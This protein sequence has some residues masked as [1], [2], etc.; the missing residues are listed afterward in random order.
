MGH[1][2]LE[3]I[4][5]VL[6]SRKLF[7]YMPEQAGECDAFE[8]SFAKRVGVRHAL[9]LTSGTNALVAALAAYGIGEGD[10]VIIPAYTFVA[11]AG[12]VRMVGAKPVVVNIDSEFGLSVED[13]R[14]KVTARTKAIL[15]VHMDGLSADMHGILELAREKGLIVIEDCAQA[16]GGS[17]HGRRLGSIGDAG[18]F[19]LNENKII[20]CGEGGIVTTSCSDAFERMMCLQDLSAR[21][22]PSKK[23][24]FSSR[25]QSYVGMSMRVSEIQGAMIRVQLERL[26]PILEK[27]RARKNALI[28]CLG[29]ARSVT[30]PRGHCTQ[31]DCGTA[32]HLRFSDPIVA[33]AA[34]IHL[35][36]QGIVAAFPTSRPAHVAWKWLELIDPERAAEIRAELLPTVDALTCTLR[37]EIDPRLTLEE[38]LKIGNAM[39][40]LADSV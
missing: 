30:I 16:M 8:S 14:Q 33:G 29:S 10:E 2:E 26:D 9:L 24:Q 15:P 28:E 18:A 7:R 36:K 23:G 40:S 22:N 5:R 38:T 1:E 11:T 13:A 34:S 6:E 4:R 25:T 32:L 17:H 19:S 3:A 35:R 39:R 20:S 37:Y 21:Y 31:G 12:A 27:L